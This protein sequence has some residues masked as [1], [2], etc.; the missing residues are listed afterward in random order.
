MSSYFQSCN[1]LLEFNLKYNLFANRNILLSV[2]FYVQ[3]L[4][5]NYA[6]SPYLL[7]FYLS[8]IFQGVI[9][10]HKKHVI[11]FK[12]TEGIS[13]KTSIH[14]S[15]HSLI[16]NEL[17]MPIYMYGC[18]LYNIHNAYYKHYFNYVILYAKTFLHTEAIIRTNVYTTIY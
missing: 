1:I 16:V 5:E 9:E 4:N 8:L 6:Y 13:K 15:L 12:V 18:I 17:Y 7:S 10:N 3:S 2:E 11:S 14:S